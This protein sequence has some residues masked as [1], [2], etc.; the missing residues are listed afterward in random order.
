[1]KLTT[2][3]FA[4]ALVFHNA[5]PSLAQG[6]TT[7]DLQAK[8]K[9]CAPL[10]ILQNN[11]S[12]NASITKYVKA[13]TVTD[14][15]TLVKATFTALVSDSLSY[16]NC[17]GQT[18]RPDQSLDDVSID[19]DNIVSD[20][21]NALQ[22]AL[23][24]DGKLADKIKVI[25]DARNMARSQIG[26]L[27]TGDRL[28]PRLDQVTIDAV[29][30]VAT[31]ISTTQVSAGVTLAWQSLS[32]SGSFGKAF[33]DH[34][35]GDVLVA[36]ENF[37]RAWRSYIQ[38]ASGPKLL[39]SSF[40]NPLYDAAAA[41][42]RDTVQDQGTQTNKPVTVNASSTAPTGG[43]AAASPGG[44]PSGGASA[45]SMPASPAGAAPGSGKKP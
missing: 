7:K 15:G 10:K 40:V 36:L 12:I 32:V 2:V 11:D 42:V 39:K 14:V 13:L 18:A 22:D 19:L 23:A 20:V 16:Y 17:L 30:P 8:A 41:T 9:D 29:I 35:A 43:N 34:L 4:L 5:H 24:T 21:S 31:L 1:M 37:N 25:N 33:P 3:L 26:T 44:A 6:N 45:A 38:G 28:T 27:P